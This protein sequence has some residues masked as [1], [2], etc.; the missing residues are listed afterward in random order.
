MSFYNVYC[1]KFSP[2]VIIS[3]REC[4]KWI[5]IVL[6]PSVVNFYLTFVFGSF[7]GFA[8]MMCH[9]DLFLSLLILFWHLKLATCESKYR[10]FLTVILK[11]GTDRKKKIK[12][13]TVQYWTPLTDVV[14]KFHSKVVWRVIHV[15]YW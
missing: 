9:L 4:T 5:S 11:V 6:L 8:N 12:V 14:F 7:Q 3:W 13:G 15:Y 1:I 2:F 10:D